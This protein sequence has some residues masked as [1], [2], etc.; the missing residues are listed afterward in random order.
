VQLRLEYFQNTG[1]RNLRL[2]WRTPGAMRAHAAASTALD[3]NVN[4]YLPKGAGWYDFWTNQRHAGGQS[5]ASA[6]PLDIVPLYVR[7]G[8]I[9]PMGPVLQYATER[10][11]APYEIRIYPGADASFTLYE[12]DNE[13][14]NYEKG[15]SARTTLTWNDAARTLTVGARQGSYPGLV[16]RRTL[17]L[18]LAD[19]GNGKGIAA[20]APTRTLNYAGQAAV[21]KFDKYNNTEMK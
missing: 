3:L 17:N 21:I 12:D 5:V 7:A 8:T 10:P 19:A 6:A 9:L 4:T 15:Q 13:T 20:A 1:E 2:A 14:Y 11:D 18:V 16:K